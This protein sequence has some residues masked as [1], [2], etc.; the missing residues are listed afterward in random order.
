MIGLITVI[1]SLWRRM[2]TWPVLW[3]LPHAVALCFHTV[4]YGLLL[5]LSTNIGNRLTYPQMQLDGAVLD[6]YIV[7]M[8]MSKEPH[9]LTQAGVH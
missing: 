8:H 3:M 1:G 2:G 6:K 5:Y 7:R 9:T 4:L